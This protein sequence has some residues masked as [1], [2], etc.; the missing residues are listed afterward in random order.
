MRKPFPSKVVQF[1]LE[2]GLEFPLETDK[3]SIQFL[4]QKVEKC[5]KNIREDSCFKL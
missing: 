4:S 3:L 1:V 2:P 5:S